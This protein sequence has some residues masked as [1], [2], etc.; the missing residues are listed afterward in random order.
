[1][2][3]KHSPRPGRA[4]RRLGNALLA[5][6]LGLAALAAA[7]VISGHYQV[8][9]VLSGSM[10]PLLPVGGVVVTERVPIASLRVGD[11]VVF[12]RPDRPAEL[13]VHRIVALTPGVAGPVVRTKGDANEVPDPW[14]ISLRGTTAYRASFSMP[15]LGYVAVWVHGPAGRQTFLVLGLLLLVGAGI[16]SLVRYLRSQGPSRIFH[17]RTADSGRNSVP[18]LDLGGGFGSGP[19]C[20]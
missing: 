13:V 12:H 14:Q 20:P 6:V 11:V 17:R 2:R 4:R 9:P 8:R 5:A 1:M 7:A 19:H 15:V 3:G 18:Q 16:G 10:V